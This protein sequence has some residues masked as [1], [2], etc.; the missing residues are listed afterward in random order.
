MRVCSIPF[1]VVPFAAPASDEKTALLT[2]NNEECSE[3]NLDDTGDS[4]Q[5]SHSLLFKDQQLNDPKLEGG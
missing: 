1:Q 4:L 3:K 2:E 5:M